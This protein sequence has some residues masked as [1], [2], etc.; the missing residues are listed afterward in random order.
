MRIMLTI[1]IQLALCT[2]HAQT[3]TIPISKP[4]SAIYYKPDIEA[5]YPGGTKDWIHYLVRNLRYPDQAVRKNIQGTVVVQFIV[6]SNGSV[7]QV[8]AISGPKELQ[9]ESMRLIEKVD[10]WIPAMY[11]GRKVNS[12]KTQPVSYK[13]E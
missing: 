3:D 7:H 8:T 2:A 6:D 1:L 9:A 11:N 12:W 10:I 4:D 5:S 13:L